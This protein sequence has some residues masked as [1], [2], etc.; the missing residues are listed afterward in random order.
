MEWARE[1]GKQ[2]RFLQIDF[3]GKQAYAVV[4]RLHG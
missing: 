3:A 4:G 2:S 1:Y